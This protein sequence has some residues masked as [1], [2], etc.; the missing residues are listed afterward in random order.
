MGMRLTLRG[1]FCGGLLWAVALTPD[2]A[3]GH[4]SFAVFFDGQKSISITGVVKE[5]QFVNPHGLIKLSVANAD[6]STEEWRVETNSPSILRR[7]GWTPESLTVG[8]KVTIDGWPARDNSHYARL[9]Q[10][11]RANGDLVGRP[12]DSEG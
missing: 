12:L 10:A 8:E 6:G 1:A 2:I 3:L 9:R 4:H 11:K 5:F 7:R